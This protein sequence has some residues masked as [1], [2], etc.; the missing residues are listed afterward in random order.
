MKKVLLLALLLSKGCTEQNQEEGRQELR[1]KA[2]DCSLGK[3][4]YTEISLHDV[5]D[6]DNISAR[7]KE[8]EAVQAQILQYIDEKPVDI[9][10]CQVTVSLRTNYCHA[11]KILNNHTKP[12]Q[13]IV[14]GK[15]V[16]VTE[17]QCRNAITTKKFSLNYEG[18]LV[19]IDMNTDLTARGDK[20]IEGSVDPKSSMCTP[21]Q[22]WLYKEF[23][24]NSILTMEYD[25]EITQKTNKTHK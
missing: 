20:I 4:N 22:F 13:Q 3:A 9:L 11:V 15:P 8:E 5:K 1:I 14:R 21:K 12:A 23:Y 19:S 6:C 2:Y 17:P 25:I 7:Y 18:R 16:S 10:H 24:E